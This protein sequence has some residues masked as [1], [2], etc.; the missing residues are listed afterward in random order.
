M[1]VENNPGGG[2]VIDHDWRALI[3]NALWSWILAWIPLISLA[4]KIGTTKYSYD[5]QYT[6]TYEYGL[7]SKKDVNIDLR[8]VKSISAKDSPLSGGSLVVVENNDG[9]DVLPYVKNARDVAAKLRMLV[10]EASRRN[11]DV[12]NRV[13]A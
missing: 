8:R 6:L 1:T 9:T 12:Q 4:I 2:L 13:I 5:G 7:I 11:G 3:G 10:D